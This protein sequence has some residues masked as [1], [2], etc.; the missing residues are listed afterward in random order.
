MGAS[1]GSDTFCEKYTSDKVKNWCDE[2]ERLSE[3]ANSQPQTA[4]AAFIHGELHKYTYF[5][6]TIPHINTYHKPF[7]EII[8]K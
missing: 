2:I 7:H 8:T 6:R 4:Y 3:F 1:L 5:I